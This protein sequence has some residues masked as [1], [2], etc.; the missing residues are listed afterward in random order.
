MISGYGRVTAIDYLTYDTIEGYAILDDDGNIVIGDIS[1]RVSA[2]SNN[3]SASGIYASEI[4]I[5]SITPS[6]VILANAG[7]ADPPYTTAT[8]AYGISSYNQ[9]IIGRI[10]GTVGAF[11][12]SGGM[13]AN[14]YAFGKS[15]NRFSVNELSGSVQAIGGS[16]ENSADATGISYAHEININDLSGLIDVTGGTAK[17]SAETTGMDA[18]GFFHLEDSWSMGK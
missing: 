12:G 15:H 3:A 8:N 10:D 17:F 6:G 5:D 4:N 2:T 11:G 16:A 14:A 13:E 9:A 18:S 1:A 7:H